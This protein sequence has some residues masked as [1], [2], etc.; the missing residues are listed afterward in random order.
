MIDP[1]LRRGPGVFYSWTL[2]IK[3]GCPSK[4]SGGLGASRLSVHA[5]TAAGSRLF[6]IPWHVFPLRCQTT[7]QLQL[8]DHSPESDLIQLCAC[9]TPPQVSPLECA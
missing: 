3:E 9:V 5:N 1:R 6:G 8:R 7:M 2:R 4:A